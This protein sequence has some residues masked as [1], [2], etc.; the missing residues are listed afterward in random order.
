MGLA[1]RRTHSPVAKTGFT[2]VE[3]IIVI[4]I[5]GVISVV[6]APRFFDKDAYASRGFYEV[7]LSALRYAHKLAMGSG[8]H[9][10]VNFS[11]TGVTVK[12]RASCTSGAFD[13]DVKHP[14]KPDQAF[15]ESAPGVSIGSLSI[16]YDGAGRPYDSASGV[17][18]SAPVTLAVDTRTLQVEPYTGFVHR[19]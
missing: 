19:L 10:Q 13:V 1:M 2:L 17:L 18:L 6:V 3:L 11:A 7:S 8:C 4:V 15:S 9:T 14:G 12:Q 16:Y 5:I